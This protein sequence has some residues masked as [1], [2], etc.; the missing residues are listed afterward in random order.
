MAIASESMHSSVDIPSVSAFPSP[1][2][3]L[4]A[5]A[6][7]RLD[8]LRRV[9][10]WRT[11]DAREAVEGASDVEIRRLTAHGVRLDA[12]AVR[13]DVIGAATTGRRCRI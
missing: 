5:W 12:N 9:S 6:S 13:W 2:S 11:Y 8:Q 3:T 10:L 7:G 4:L 1:R